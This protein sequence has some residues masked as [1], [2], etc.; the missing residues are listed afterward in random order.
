MFEH[1]LSPIK[2][3]GLE[4][5]NR[6]ILPAMGTRMASEKGEIT[7]RLIAY[8][9]AR[10]KGG[11]GLNIVE[12]TAVHRPSSPAHFVW[13]CEDSL[14]EGHKK[15][16]DAIHEN[17]GK[18]GIQLWQGGLAVSMDPSAQILL[19]SDMNLGQYTIPGITL[20]QIKEI[21]FCYGQAARRAVEAGYDCIE[22]HLA[23]NYLPHSF[24][25]GGLNHRT[26]EYGGSF[27]NR[28][29]FPLEV[30]DAIRNNIPEDMPLFIRIDAHDDFLEKGLTIEEVI[31]FCNIAKEH[32]VDVLDVSRGNILTAATIYEVPPID[33]PQGFNIE[34]AS[35]IRKET[36]MLTIG[37]GR[38]NHEDFAEKLLAEDKV[39]MVVMGRAQ[40]ADPELVNKLKEGRT[41]DIIHCIGCD[42]GCYDGFT[43]VVNREFITC[44]RNPNIGHEAEHT[45]TKTENPKHVWIVGGGVGGMEAAKV[46][47]ELGHEPEIFEASD[48]LGGQFIIAGKA[49]GKK[50]MEDATIEMAKQT[51][52][53]CKIHLN[54]K[55]TPEMIEEKKPDHVI[56]A[57]GALPIALRLDGEDQIHHVQANDVLMG[58]EKLSGY[59]AIIGGGLVGLEA[60]DYLATQGCKVTVLEMKDKI[61][62][63]L[64][65][66]R[67]IAVM[68]KMNQLKVELKPSSKVNSLSKEGVVLESGQ[69]IPCEHVVYAVGSKS[70]DNSELCSMMD[71]LSI[72]YQIIGD[73]KAA[74]RA[75]NAIEEGYYAAMEV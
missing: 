26:D 21:V 23:H 53:I 38:I 56:I 67:Q 57:T 36:N 20:E 65:S 55:V 13:I 75:L 69:T 32:G 28:C 44:M 70:V 39:D 66:L 40:L 60:A 74:R 15:L 14:I 49:P 43:D 33:V 41:Q 61:G 10:A 51:E 31:D 72:P 30:I 16:T 27:E 2:I 4:L 35:R 58:K 45:F 46:L 8:H 11:C 19:P 48:H 62:A 42:Q 29:R 3:R 50:E 5:K 6:I 54:T 24:L 47:K 22:F 37:V 59:I 71:K 17:G 73:A 68:M 18:A 52:R 64:G 7:D 25:S 34:N 1:L 9:A 63:D 12:V